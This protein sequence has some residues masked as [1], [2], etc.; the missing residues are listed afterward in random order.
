MIPGK[1]D[2][3]V[4][5]T[6]EGD[7]IGMTIDESAMSHIMSVLTD[8]Y[9]DPELAVI[10]EY[11]TNARDAHIEAGV[12]KPIQVFLPTPL[13]PTFRIKDE[14]TGLDHED[15][16]NVYSRYGTSTKRETNEQTG[17]LGLGC[18]SA[19]TYTPQFNVKGVKDG[20]K[21]LVSISRDEDGAGT[22]TVVDSGPTDEP[23]GVE[24]IVPVKPHNQFEIKC[25]NFFKYWKPDT[26]R[27]NEQA[28]P[29][30]EGLEL[31]PSM[32]LFEKQGYE[33][34][35][36]VVMGGVA[37]PIPDELSPVDRHNQKWCL[38]AE[39]GMG[40][41]HFT[42]SR[43][44]LQMTKTTKKRL[45]LL[46]EE[47]EK[48]ASAAA[49]KEIAKCKT[50]QEALVKAKE[51]REALLMPDLAI[52]WNGKEI[53]KTFSAGERASTNTNSAGLPEMVK[54]RFQIH[55]IYYG[56]ASI[57]TPIYI[58]VAHTMTAL[59]IADFGGKKAVANHRRKAEKYAEEKSINVNRIVYCKEA[60]PKA[61]KE[62]IDPIAFVD[63]ETVKA[64]KLP[65]QEGYGAIEKRIKGSFPV[66]D[67]EG[68]FHDE[69]DAN[70]ISQTNVYYITNIMFGERPMRNM[71]HMFRGFN[72]TATIVKMAL[73]REEKFLR[74]FPKAERLFD[75]FKSE[76]KKAMDEI[77]GKELE[78]WNI[79]QTH[80]SWLKKL[81]PE[82]IED[83]ELKR[84][85]LLARLDIKEKAEKISKLNREIGY[86]FH[87][88]HLDAKAPEYHP[89]KK[90]PLLEW[91]ERNGYEEPDLYLYLNMKHNKK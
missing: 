29:K 62:W 67:E 84:Y 68:K 59:F 86:I 61:I 81:K 9:S 42:P 23:N 41:V 60:V 89:Y 13:A 16:R 26:V 66:W 72:P 5:S 7:K 47:Y 91:I 64:I 22:M 49:Q 45:E 17:V 53:P 24:I 35:S 74:D 77:A 21:T 88:L 78:A 80:L 57:S 33:D 65:V 55:D 50:G 54:D 58:D 11:S 39:V 71:I 73:N 51:W 15:I 6:I 8:L 79:Q 44:A 25:Q 90:Y 27:I 36:V 19:L 63:Y 48:L 30:R 87:D 4:Q 1:N 12:N 52:T 10:R 2:V 70:D 37:Y 75:A 18:K 38:V 83:K 56:S 46:K 40:E 69:M 32:W 20:V 76:A 82:L 28:P 34:K 31:S 3:T 85:V 14:G 43:E